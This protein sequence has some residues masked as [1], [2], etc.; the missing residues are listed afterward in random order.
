MNTTKIGSI[1]SILLIITLMLNH[2]MFNLP[3]NILLS[4][5]SS[6]AVSVA[7]VSILALFLTLFICKLFNKFPGMD[8]LDICDYLFGKWFKFIIGIFFIIYIFA[9]GSIVLRDFCEGLKIIY[10]RRT[11]IYYI[12]G[13]FVALVA[14]SNIFGEKA[15]IKTNLLLIPI[16]L[17]SILFIFIFNVKNFVP[18]RIFPILGEGFNK[19]FIEGTSNIYAFS[20]LILIYFIQPFLKDTKKFK[21]I[22]IVSVLISAFYLLLCIACLIFMFPALSEEVGI[23][24][25]YLVSRY[26]EFGTFFQRID[27]VFLLVWILELGLYLNICMMLVIRIFKKITNIEHSAIMVYPASLI[28]FS[29]SLIPKNLADINAFEGTFYKNM[30]LYFVIIANVLILILAN[31]KIFI[32]SKRIRKEILIE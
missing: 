23:L 16:V 5:G 14:A 31:I 1:T 9:S 15:V 10:F 24:P 4:T 6:A 30:I 25:I 17:I 18:Q 12:V 11:F 2:I 21:T 7:Y 27:A 19:T 8:V 26:I 3:K 29:L 28:L 32:K 22:S 20:C 13:F